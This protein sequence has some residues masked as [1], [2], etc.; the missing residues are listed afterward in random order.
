MFV[1]IISVAHFTHSIFYE[2][3]GFIIIF[4][5]S[6]IQKRVST[7]LLHNAFMHSHSI[8]FLFQHKTQKNV[9]LDLAFDRI[10]D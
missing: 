9:K 7:C 4:D 10:K 3:L 8:K 5:A 6:Q 2:S 1:T